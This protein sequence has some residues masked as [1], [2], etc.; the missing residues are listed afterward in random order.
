MS[1]DAADD[2]S[3]HPS[4][5]AALRDAY[6]ERL[7]PRLAEIAALWRSV[8]ARGPDDA[9]TA[10]VQ[11]LVHRLAG[12]AGLYGFAAVGEAAAALEKGLGAWVAGGVEAAAV[13]QL[14]QDLE[15]A[16]ALD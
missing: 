8:R 14:V 5:F 1:D 7:G 12:S 16:G 4:G 10:D 11:D 3:D 9:A 2:A 15:N 13:D 6:R